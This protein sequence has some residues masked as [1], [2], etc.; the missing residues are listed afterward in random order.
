[1]TTYDLLVTGH[2][3]GAVAWVGSGTFSHVLGE[4]ILKR[5]NGDEM[6]TFL[7]DLGALAL[8]WFIPVSLLTVVCGIAA[9][10][11][12]PWSFGALWIDIGLAMFVISF[13]IGATYL[14][15]QSEK[16]AK[17]AESEGADSQTFRSGLKKFMT[18]GRFETALLWLTV[19]V[20]VIKPG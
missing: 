5:G 7:D 13:L 20:M 18:I 6:A 3:V 2:V 11:D 19:I 15:P 10:I 1:M 9:A 14:G 4:R 17:V 16:L 8:R 12:G